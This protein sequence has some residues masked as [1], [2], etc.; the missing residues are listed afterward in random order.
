MFQKKEKDPT[1]KLF[2][3][4]EW[5]RSLTEAQE[6]TADV[7]EGSVTC[8]Q[9]EVESQKVRPIQMGEFLPEVCLAAILGA[10]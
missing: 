2:D 5:I 10:Q 7:P 9:Q 8:E 3:D 6:V 1:S 4:N